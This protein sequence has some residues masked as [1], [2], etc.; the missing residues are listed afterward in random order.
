MSDSGEKE[1]PAGIFAYWYRIKDE[2]LRHAIVGLIENCGK[3]QYFNALRR[4]SEITRLA[5]NNLQD[6]I[7]EK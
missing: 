6:V 2:D 3:E 7:N 1:I 5:T 4:V